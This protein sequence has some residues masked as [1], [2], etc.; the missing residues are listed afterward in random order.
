MPDY[1]SHAICAQKI[2]EN[3]NKKTRS[4]ISDVGLFYLGAQGGDVF[5]T[6][7]LYF[8]QSNLGRRLHTLSA[9]ELFNAL[10]QGNT[11]Y[12]C[13]FAT[14]YA[15][16]SSLHPA[17]YAFEKTSRTPFAHMRFEADLGLYI[18]RKYDVTRRILPRERVVGSTF[19]VYD[20]IVKV[21]PQITLTGV[22]R[23]LKR[24]F[25]F[26]RELIRHKRTTYALDYD[27]SSLSGAV[28]DGVS[29]GISCVEAIAEG[30]VDG[31]LFSNPFN[32]K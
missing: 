26:S 22:E 21:A 17:V 5:F 23:C 27:F 18:S 11:S 8:G 25:L 1:F 29:L 14:H 32:A 9:V 30:N 4:A 13:G 10:I 3:C 19:K 6:Y 12:A 16:D 15:I 28:E 20:S 24:Y 7:K 2:L 31:E